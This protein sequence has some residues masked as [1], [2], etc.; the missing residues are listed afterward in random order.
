M[1]DILR[2]H[3]PWVIGGIVILFWIGV[4]LMAHRIR[5]PKPKRKRRTKYRL[6]EPDVAFQNKAETAAAR[7]IDPATVVNRPGIR[8]DPVQFDDRLYVYIKGYPPL[9]GETGTAYRDRVGKELGI[10][11]GEFASVDLVRAR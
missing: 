5:A 9:E 8:I 7:Q 11:F 10:K 4:A 2:D 1:D 6:V 3:A